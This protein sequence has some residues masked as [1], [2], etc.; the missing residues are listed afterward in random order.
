MAK[1]AAMPHRIEILVAD[2]T[3]LD[4]DAIVNAANRS[5]C[6]AAAA[7][8]APSTALP[9]PNCSPNAARWAAAKPARPRSPGLSPAGP[10]RHPHGRP[11]LAR[12]RCRRGRLLASAYANSLALAKRHGLRSIAF[13]GHLDRR[14]C[15]PADRAAAHRRRRPL[16]TSCAA[17]H[18]S[19]QV[20]F[21]CFSVRL[22]A[23]S[24]AGA[25]R[26]SSSSHQSRAD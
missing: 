17:T 20:V 9:A 19:A 12:R 16:V 21:C 4:V 15:L 13:P 22:G 7:S 2:I 24:R 11:G 25:A 10:P 6:S 8:T 3:T 1:A 18:I 23:A 26:S 14:L 5:A